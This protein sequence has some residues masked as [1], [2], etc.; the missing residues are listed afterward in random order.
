MREDVSIHAPTWGATFAVCVKLGFQKLNHTHVGCDM[1]TYER[2]A[3]RWSPRT[4]GCD[5]LYCY[6]VKLDVSIHAPVVR[7]AIAAMA[8]DK[9][10]V[11]IHAPTWGDPLVRHLR[12]RFQFQSAPTWGATL[13]L[14]FKII[15]MP[16]MHPRGVRLLTSSATEGISLLIHAPVSATRPVHKRKAPP[17]SIHAPTWGA[18][19]AWM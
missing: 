18:T 13:V 6:V 12:F 9:S 17:V 7:R 11:S 3:R 1:R 8:A 5:P 16:I 19:S 15:K 2:K 10:N 14:A 4:R